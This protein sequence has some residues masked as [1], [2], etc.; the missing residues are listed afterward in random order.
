MSGDIKVT[1]ICVFK[2]SGYP[3][4][5]PGNI[6]MCPAANPEIY[7]DAT[8]TGCQTHLKMDPQVHNQYLVSVGHSFDA[9]HASRSAAYSFI[10]LALYLIIEI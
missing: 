4:H 1:A 10:R 6:Y 2:D 9:H 3:C 5:M 8:E 7:V